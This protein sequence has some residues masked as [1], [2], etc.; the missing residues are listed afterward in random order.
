MQEKA[1]DVVVITRKVKGLFNR[2]SETNLPGIVSDFENLFSTF[3]RR[4]VTEAFTQQLVHVL[5]Q[6]VGLLESFVMVYV[7]LLGQISQFVGTDILAYFTLFITQKFT[8][9]YDLTKKS[10][11]SSKVATADDDREKNLQNM[12]FFVSFLYSFGLVSVELLHDLALEFTLEFDEL[13]VELLLKLLKCNYH[14]LIIYL[15][16]SYIFL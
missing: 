1:S 4:L 3:P 12:I 14:C 16:F 10:S 9:A 6:Q 5:C 8:D 7:S 2:L 13:S 15:Y 11:T